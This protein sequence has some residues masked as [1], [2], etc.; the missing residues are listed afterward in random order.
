[1]R[2]GVFVGSFNPVH[3]GHI[4]VVNYLINHH[5]VDKV[6]IIPTLSYWDKNDLADVNDR[7]NMLKFFENEK[8]IIEPK[9]NVNQYTYQVMNA[10]ENDYPNDDLMLIIGADNI[11]SFDKWMNYHDLLKRKIIV[12][13]RNNIDI[14]SYINK[15]EEKDNFV[16][17]QEFDYVNT[18]STDIKAD[19]SNNNLDPRVYNYILEHNLY[20]NKKIV[21]KNYFF[22]D[23]ILNIAPPIIVGK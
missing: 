7:I 3:N 8:I 4:H 19:L 21:C 9:Y 6:M 5:I 17:V 14:S 15:Y 2:L 11:I 22:N 13:N 23:P 1:M 20:Q 18:S 16:V 12:V 10:I